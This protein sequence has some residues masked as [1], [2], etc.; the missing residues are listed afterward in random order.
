L[1]VLSL[2]VEA[3]V[4]PSPEKA[5]ANTVPEWP[6]KTLSLPAVAEVI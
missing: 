2:L 1:T 4:W 3:K 5:T 6:F